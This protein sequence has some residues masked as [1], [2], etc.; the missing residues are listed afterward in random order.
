[1]KVDTY[2]FGQV[3]VDPEKVINFPDGI[4]GFENSR[5]FM[6]AHEVDKGDPVSFTLQSLD[7]PSLAFPVIDPSVLGFNYEL[8][9]NEEEMTKLQNPAPEDITVVL[10]LSK[11]EGEA[12]PG[13]IRA[14]VRAP[15]LLNTKKQIGLQ[16]VLVRMRQNI[17]LSNLLSPI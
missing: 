16:K 6:L 10:I 2:L 13:G 7:D 8:E 15:I 3:E 12:G 5:R 14:N 4:V 11:A 1:M 17:T 9:L